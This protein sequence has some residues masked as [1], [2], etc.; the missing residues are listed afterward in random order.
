[1]NLALNFNPNLNPNLGGLLSNLMNLRLLALSKNCLH[2]FF[3][4]LDICHGH[5]KWIAP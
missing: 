4:P 5:L 3:E 2:K 1:M